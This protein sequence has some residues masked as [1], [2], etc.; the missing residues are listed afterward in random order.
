MPILEVKDLKKKF[1]NTQVLKGID[2]ELEKG[3]G[4]ILF[5]GAEISADTELGGGETKIDIDGG[6][7]EID[8]RTAE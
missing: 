5:N 8:I 7:G 4:R 2:F 3:L 1:E 6:I